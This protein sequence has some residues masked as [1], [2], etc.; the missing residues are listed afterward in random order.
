MGQFDAF[1]INTQSVKPKTLKESWGDLYM[2]QQYIADVLNRANSGYL[3]VGIWANNNPRDRA[4]GADYPFVRNEQ[5]LALMRNASRYCY[6]TVSNA[7]GFI[8]TLTSYVIST[9]FNVTCKSDTRLKLAQKCQKLLS[10]WME[11]N[12]FE[13]LQEE[14]FQRTRIDGEMFLRMYPQADGDLE[15]R[16]VEPECVTQ[17]GGSL[18]ED[19][20]FGIKTNPLDTQNILEYNVRY[21]GAE[22]YQGLTDEAVKPEDIVH[23]KINCTGAM[24]RGVPDFSFNTLESFTLAAKLTRNIGEG[25]AVQS[26]IAA[27]REHQTASMQQ[28]DDFLDTQTGATPVPPFPYPGMAPQSFHGYQQFQPGSFLDIP[29]G[30]KYVP[31]PGATNVEPHLQVLQA[32][33]RAA[34][35]RWSAPEWAVSARSDSMSYASSLTAESPFLRTCL[36]LQRD[37]KRVFRKVLHK[38]LDI[39]ALAGKIPVEWE[40]HV[41]IDVAAPAMEVRDRGAEA[42]ANQI[43]FDMGI[44]SK[45]TIASETGL[46]YSQEQ[47]YMAEEHEQSAPPPEQAY[48]VDKNADNDINLPKEQIPNLNAEDGDVE[49]PTA[50]KKKTK[51]GKSTLTTNNRG[52]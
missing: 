49:M 43:Y 51:K 24:K 10:H 4:Y 18:E 28:V 30:T 47:E 26:A 16:F 22:A 9:G 23:Y 5:D 42:R 3:G 44:K 15:V 19:Y 48:N 36:R 45:H 27:V 34:G 20:I 2:P 12:N 29:G 25:A 13:A 7:S 40:D 39:A 11:E 17:P 8:T 52:V 50:N 14:I 32:V 37:Y 41:Q 1:N 38:V 6:R 33:L 35:M 21:F 46:N 31:P